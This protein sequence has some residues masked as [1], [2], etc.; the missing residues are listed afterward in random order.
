VKVEGSGIVV[1]GA[2]GGIGRALAARLVAE[3]ARVVINDLDPERTQAT[4]AEIGAHAIPG[5][6]DAEPNVLG[7]RVVG[8]RGF[9]HTDPATTRAALAALI[10][11]LTLTPTGATA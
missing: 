2:A 6:D 5:V 9:L 3:G 11:H 7:A 10:P 1:T 8:M 4:A